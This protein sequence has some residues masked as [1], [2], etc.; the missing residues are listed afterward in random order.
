MPS[1][2]QLEIRCFTTGV[3]QQN[4]WLVR[5]KAAGTTL[6]VDAGDGIAELLQKPGTLAGKRLDAVLLTHTHMDHVWGLGALKRIFA[7]VPVYAHEG[8]LPLLRALPQQ[9]AM[10]GFPARLEAAPDPDVLVAPGAELR[11]GGIR[12]RAI[13]TAGHTPGGLCWLLNEKHLFA[14]DMLFAGSVGRTDLP[15]GNP[16]RMVES[17]KLLLELDDAVVVYSGHGPETTIGAERVEN[18]FLQDLA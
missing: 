9:G 14:G 13:H 7:A 18:P 16:G 15:G 1:D 8:E 6:L 3:F 17:L 11:F 10:I 12:A 5:E 4:T 2:A